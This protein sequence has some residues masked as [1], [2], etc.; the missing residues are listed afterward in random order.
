MLMQ[1]EEMIALNFN[2]FSD[3][4]LAAMPAALAHLREIADRQTWS[5]KGPVGQTE[6]NP[7]YRQGFSKE[8]T[9][10]VKAIDG[11][12][13]ECQQARYWYLKGALQRMPNLEID[14]DKL[15]VQS[16]LQELGFSETMVEALDAAEADYREEATPFELKNCLSHL[17]SFLEHLHRETAKFVATRKGETIVDR[18]G[19]ATLYLR[20]QSFYTKQHEAFAASLYTLISDESVHPLGAD[21]GVRTTAAQRR[22]RV[23]RDVPQRRRKAGYKAV[24]GAGG[25]GKHSE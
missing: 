9:E 5:S 1:L 10:I 25:P 11:V 12:V 7:F 2:L 16:F 22:A 8:G 19:D 17:R 3:G 4:E 24:V 21:R 13:T 15:R 18:W 20:N 6:K 23:W 14:N